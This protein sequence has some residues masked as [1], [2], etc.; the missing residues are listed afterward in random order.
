[1]TEPLVD[2]ERLGVFRV[3]YEI[4]KEEPEFVRKVMGE[5]IIVRAEYMYVYKAIEY[6]AISDRFD[7]IEEG[8]LL[9]VYI[10]KWSEDE[11]LRCIRKG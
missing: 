4:I 7:E 11:G 5:C 10:W 1:M 6:Q 3:P 2:H 9:P 8:Q